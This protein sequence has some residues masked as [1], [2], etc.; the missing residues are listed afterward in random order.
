MV[1]RRGDT[2]PVVS[3]VQRAVGTSADG[4]FGPMTQSAV[5]AFQR[6]HGVSATGVVDAATWRKLLTSQVVSTPS[7]KATHPALSKYRNTT[8]HV[9]STG[10]AVVALQKRLDLRPAGGNYGQKTKTR[11]QTFQ[12]RHGLAA[13]GVVGPATWTALGA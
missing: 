4:D 3:A 7:R 6:N 12:S 9:G 8:L 13:N 11:V 2:G 5:T 1:L 10:P